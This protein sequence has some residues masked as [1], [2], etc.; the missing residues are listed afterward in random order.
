MP[1][2]VYI[3]IAKLFEQ[4]LELNNNILLQRTFVLYNYIE[5]DCIESRHEIETIENW[6]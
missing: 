6:P 4:C 2:K 3:Q 5:K 1:Q